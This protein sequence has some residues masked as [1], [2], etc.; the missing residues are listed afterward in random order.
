MKLQWL[1]ILVLM[2]A[3]ACSQGSAAVEDRPNFLIILADDLGYS[4]LGVLGSEIRTPNIDALAAEGVI[5][6]NYY[7]SPSCSPTRA[8]LLSGTDAHPAGLGTMAGDADENQKGHAGY[9]GYLS[10][11][12]VAVS[13]LLR[14]AGYHTY[15]AGKWHLGV[16]PELSPERRG[17]EKSFVTVA[18]GASHFGDAAPLMDGYPAV[19]RENGADVSIPEDFYSSDFYT[20]KLIEYLED[21]SDGRPFFV[22]AAYTAPHWP[23]HAPDDYIDR[24]RGLYDDGYDA[25]RAKRLQNLI[26]GHVVPDV[27]VPDRADWVPAWDSLDE[28]QKKIEARRMEIYAAMVESMDDNIGRLIDYLKRTGQYE[29]TVV[30]FSSDNGA[31][32]NNIG[33]MS[34]NEDWIPTRFDNSYENMGRKGS[35][36]WTGPGWAQAQSAPF[37]L[38]KAHTTEGG[39]RTPA[40]VSYRDFEHEGRRTDTFASVKDIA[41]TLLELAGVDHPRVYDGREVAP[42]EGKSMVSFLSGETDTI[43]GDDAVMGWELFGRRAMLKGN[44]KLVW[45]WEPYGVERWELFDLSEDPSES[46]NLAE[47][48]PEKLQELIAAWEDYVRANDVILPARDMGYG[49]IDGTR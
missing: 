29:N 21:G 33:T 4:D 39:V 34:N 10:D 23:L 37:R 14:D 22:Y 1:W 43:H 47:E 38:F 40:I 17:F 36:V 6:T 5:F 12:V 44:W 49:L 26:D 32:G 9:E 19:Y 16:T 31:E 20:D 46:Q 41:P 15:M 18:G 28:E 30:I 7:V 45:L 24:Y 48:E 11:R 8:M 2:S 25:L 42:M 35:Y 3:L 27:P 13:N